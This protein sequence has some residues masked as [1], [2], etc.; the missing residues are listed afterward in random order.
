MSSGQKCLKIVLLS[1]LKIR[2]FYEKKQCNSAIAIRFWGNHK[3]YETVSTSYE[4]VSISGAE[5]WNFV[6]LRR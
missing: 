4:Q 1:T 6:G 2:R 5:Y 3:T